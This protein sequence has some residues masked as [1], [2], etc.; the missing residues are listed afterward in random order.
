MPTSDT[1]THASITIPLSRTRSRTSMRLVPPD[2]LSTGIVFYP[3]R[4]GLSLHGLPRRLWSVLRQGQGGDSLF[5]LADLL[6]QGRVLQCQLA[7]AH[8]QAGVL[9]PPVE[10]DLLGLVD[11]TDQE[12][13]ADGQQLHLGERDPDVARH[14]EAL[15]EDPV[16]HVDEARRTVVGRLHG[17]THRRTWATLA[18]PSS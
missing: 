18:F 11:G 2:A 9:P 5:Q 8:G 6:A 13:D 7:G 4:F 12:P 3:L 15:V 17:S 10:P 14:D 16:E 1:R